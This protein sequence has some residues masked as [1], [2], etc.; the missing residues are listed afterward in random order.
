M[1]DT[2]ND[3]ERERKERKGTKSYIIVEN[4]KTH[5]VSS[6]LPEAFHRQ[7]VSIWQHAGT[8]NRMGNSLCLRS[9]RRE[10][11]SVQYAQ[12]VTPLRGLQRHK[13]TEKGCLLG[14]QGVQFRTEQVVHARCHQ[15]ITQQW[16]LRTA[17]TKEL[18]VCIA[19]EWSTTAKY[20]GMSGWRLSLSLPSLK[21]IFFQPFKEKC[22]SEVVRIPQP[23]N[24]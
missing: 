20:C 13:Y 1:K 15:L 10:L 4:T 22:I 7:N 23:S 3:V 24:T 14:S 8:W 11:C 18:N 17:G 16:Q 19:D 12:A 9:I 21:I 6:Y 5:K 2:R